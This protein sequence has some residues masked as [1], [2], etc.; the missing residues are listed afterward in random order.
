MDFPLD[1]NTGVFIS[2]MDEFRQ[3]VE[4]LLKETIGNFMQSPQLGAKFSIHCG[5]E[6]LIKTGV[7]ETLNQ[8]QG[9]Q[10]QS[11]TVQ[12]NEVLVE[13]KYKDNI[14][15]FQFSVDNEN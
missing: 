14:V 8:I 15:N 5:D 4:I 7:E 9:V 13:V 6:L 3:D 10:V 1:L 2:S 11:C 12:N